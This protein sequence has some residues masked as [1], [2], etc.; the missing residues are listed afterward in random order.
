M[1]IVILEHHPDETSAELGATLLRHNHRLR[2]LKLHAGQAVPPDLDDVD[3]VVSMGGPMNVEDAAAH[4]WMVAEL[5]LLKAAH[6]RGVPIVGVCLGAQLVAAALGGEVK[7]MAAP[8]IG[9]HNVKLAFPGT[10]DPILQGIAWDTMQFHVHGQEVVKLPPEG[11]PLAGS[12]VCKTQ[13]FKVGLTTY[14]F[15]YHFE[16]NQGQLQRILANDQ[17]L[18]QHADTTAIAAQIDEHYTGYRRRGDRLCDNIANLLLPI[19]KRATRRL[20]GAA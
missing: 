12:K 15:Q 13:A 9:W 6:E 16:W 5:A 4:P 7:A 10:V 1:A 3:G 8:E 18:R 11:V 17:W 14:A 19:D 2:V 20:A